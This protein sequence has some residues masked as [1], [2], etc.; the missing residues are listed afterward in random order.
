M[1]VYA[2][3]DEQLEAIKSFFKQY[4]NTILIAFIVGLLLFLGWRYWNQR[5][6]KLE[7]VA[8]VN[9]EQMLQNFVNGQE[10]AATLQAMNI[11]SQH[12]KTPYASQASFVLA[13]L[14]VKNNQYDDGVKNL[15]WVI[16]HNKT[17]SMRQIAA[18][19]AARILITQGHPE[20]AL[21]SLN[22]IYDAHFS[23]AIFEVQGDA[24]LA[25]QD[26]KKAQLA[27]QQALAKMPETVAH[28]KLL[29]MELSNLS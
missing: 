12:P 16:D 22:K 29:E 18:L 20:D 15:Q 2:T 13:K 17:P 5:I 7:Q 4:G 11:V 10:D 23:P 27:Y 25:L 9:Y 28:R 6:E 24:Y 26:N 19:R 3:E 21:N 8:S 14:A 1:N